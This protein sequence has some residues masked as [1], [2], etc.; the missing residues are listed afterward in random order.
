[1]STERDLVI[2]AWLDDGPSAL[3]EETRRAISTAKRTIPQ[4]RRGFGSP[5]RDTPVNGFTRPALVAAALVVAAAGG[6]YLLRPGQPSVGGPT[7]TSTPSATVTASRASNH[8][9][10]IILRD[11][12]CT[13]EG[14][15]GRMQSPGD[16]RLSVTVRN[17]TDHYG[18]FLL[19]R[20]R[21]PHTFEE[22]AGYV[23]DLQARL[24]SGEE[25]PENDVSYLVSDFGVLPGETS[26]WRA[27]LQWIGPNS[28][29]ASFGG[30]VPGRFGTFAV[31]CSANTSATGEVLSIYAVGPLELTAFPP[32]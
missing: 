17:E 8:V 28:P 3:P 19:H 1:M 4:H 25:W 24:A 23:A 9:G 5:W 27:I 30:K 11:D 29:D 32:N 15:P 12:G 6:I 31:V 10:T 20:M 21:Y 22:G 13:W 14:N 18:S 26:R 2:A 16:G 7:T